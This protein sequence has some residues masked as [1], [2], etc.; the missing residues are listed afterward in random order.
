[1]IM[2]MMMMMMIELKACIAKHRFMQH[3]K[4][5]GSGT[6]A[7]DNAELYIVHINYLILQHK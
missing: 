2:E 5:I 7:K 3:I 6:A 1:M 4:K